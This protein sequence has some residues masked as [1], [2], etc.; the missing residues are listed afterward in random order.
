MLMI[1]F[2]L[3]AS[4]LAEFRLPDFSGARKEGKGHCLNIGELIGGNVEVATILWN[5]H[6]LCRKP[7]SAQQVLV[8]SI[9]TR[10]K[11]WPG[12]ACSNERQLV[13]IR[14]AMWR[15]IIFSISR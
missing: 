1:G 11:V 3:R 8:I 10:R 13:V 2:Y 12:L 15:S 7:K 5:E 6:N 9:S 4:D 14:A